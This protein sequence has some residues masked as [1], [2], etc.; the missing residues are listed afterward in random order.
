MGAARILVVEDDYGTAD[1]LNLLLS[2]NGYCVTDIVATGEE[3]IDVARCTHPDLILMDIKLK[4]DIDGITACEQIKKSFDIPVIFVSA[5]GD[6]EMIDRAM[7][8]N[9]SGYIVKPFKVFQLI[10]EVEKALEWHALS[11][12]K[13]EST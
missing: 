3:A 7:Q 1:F 5:Y 13:E 6:K 11:Q 9:P 4:G 2:Q 12:N 10:R 8:C